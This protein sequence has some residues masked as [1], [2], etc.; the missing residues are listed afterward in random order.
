MTGYSLHPLDWSIFVLYIAGLIT[1]GIIRSRSSRD[2]SENYI[3]AGRKVSLPGFVATLV[4][5]WYGGI[6]GVGENTFR[7]GIQTWFIFGLPYYVFALLFAWF[8]AERIRNKNVLSIPDQITDHFG[9]KPG[10]ISAVYILILASPA[11]YILSIGVFIQYFLGVPLLPALVLAT[12]VSLIY[13]WFGGFGAV[14]RTDLLQFILM[15]TGFIMLLGFAWVKIGSPVDMVQSLPEGH[16]DP[17]GGNTVQYVVVWFFIAL[18]T[19]ID[20]GFYQRCAAAASPAIARRGILIAVGFWF[21]F[22]LLTLMTG[23]YARA[24]L[25][26]DQALLAFPAL[27]MQVLPP[28]FLGLFLTAILAT[29]MSTI[30]SL[31]LISAI[32]F[33]QDIVWRLKQNSTGKPAELTEQGET[34]NSTP[35]VQFGLVIMA[36]IAVMLAW[37]FPSVVKLWYVIG[38]VI[39][40]GLLLPFLLTFTTRNIPILGLLLVPTGVSLGWFIIG[41]F[42]PS[43]WLGIE[44][45]YPGIILSV[46]LGVFYWFNWGGNSKLSRQKQKNIVNDPSP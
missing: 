16:L 29:I 20:P 44:P 46:I 18:W 22:D 1:L 9:K 36:I 15:F 27:G 33:G 41:L 8:L 45:F 24:I 23:L 37:L 14:I 6:L 2:S 26:G 21:V 19:F 43:P 42:T 10:I 39:V 7:F 32:T 40:P 30:D 35:Y 38:S 5:T 13:I 11:P 17:L 3:L 31:G 25:N 28:L 12:L 4:A 34:L